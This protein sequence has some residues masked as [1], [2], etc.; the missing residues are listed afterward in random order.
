VKRLTAGILLI[1]LATAAVTA[2]TRRATTL[3]KPVD[4]FPAT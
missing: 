3:T 2:D 1:C 4:F